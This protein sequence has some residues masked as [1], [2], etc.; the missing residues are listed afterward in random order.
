MSLSKAYM[1]K[2]ALRA[3]LPTCDLGKG[4]GIKASPATCRAL[5]PRLC[6]VQEAVPTRLMQP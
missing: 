6:A 4:K 3:P 5:L 1:S 2:G